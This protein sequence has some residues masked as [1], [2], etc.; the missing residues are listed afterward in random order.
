MGFFSGWRCKADFFKLLYVVGG[1]TLVLVNQNRDVN[2][3]RERKY[4]KQ[5][6]RVSGTVKF[7]AWKLVNTPSIF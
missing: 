6:Q 4:R 3:I 1:F 5:V 7:G 2:Y